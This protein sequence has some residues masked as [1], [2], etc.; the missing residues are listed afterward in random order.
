M[1][2]DRLCIDRGWWAGSREVSR[3]ITKAIYIDGID[4]CNVNTINSRAPTPPLLLL[5]SLL[6]LLSLLLRLLLFPR[7]LR[8]MLFQ[9]PLLPDIAVLQ[10]Y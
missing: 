4:T 6:L 10:H 2:V 1:H 7:F 8:V 9:I 3:A 5:P